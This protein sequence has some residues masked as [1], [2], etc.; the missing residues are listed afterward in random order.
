MSPDANV[1]PTRRLLRVGPLSLIFL[2]RLTTPRTLPPN[3][4]QP[5]IS[6]IPLK[7]LNN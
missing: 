2:D 5:S 4:F 1:V 3:Y 7:T 6:T